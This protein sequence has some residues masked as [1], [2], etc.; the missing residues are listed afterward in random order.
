MEHHREGMRALL[1]LL[2]DQAHF[3]SLLSEPKRRHQTYRARAHDQDLH[4]ISRRVTWAHAC[5]ESN[6]RARL[7]AVLLTAAVISDDVGLLRIFSHACARRTG[8]FSSRLSNDLPGAR[9]PRARPARKASRA[10]S[11]TARR[12]ARFLQTLTSEARTALERRLLSRAF[13]SSNA[14][15]TWPVLSTPERLRCIVVESGSNPFAARHA[16]GFD[17]TVAI[18]QMPGELPGAFAQRTMARIAGV[19]RSRRHFAAFTVLLGGQYDAAS[20]AARRLIV[21]GLT[22]HARVQDR[23]ADLLLEAPA[24]ASPEERRELLR[25]VG[26]V[27]EAS[28]S[29]RVRLC[30]GERAAAKPTARPSGVFVKPSRGRA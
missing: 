21:L 19:E 13:M 6:E 25:L 23:P 28:D 8:T 12:L 18:A 22:A 3:D 7:S 17:E 29:L 27:T 20:N 15:R 14:A 9:R 24:N 5:H 26:E 16:D 10:R 1:W 30:F 2:I 4:A 11:N